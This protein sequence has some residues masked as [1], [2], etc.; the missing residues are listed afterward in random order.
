MSVLWNLTCVLLCPLPG[1]WPSKVVRAGERASLPKQRKMPVLLP[2]RLGLR[3]VFVF[4]QWG[5]ALTLPPSRTSLV[6]VEVIVLENEWA[7]QPL[8]LLLSSVKALLWTEA[9]PVCVYW[10]EGWWEESGTLCFRV[11]NSDYL[12]ILDYCEDL[13]KTTHLDCF[14]IYSLK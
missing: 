10:S 4:F 13:L 3:E 2:S 7:F 1:Q 9:L 6:F 8:G 5:M 11:V 12:R 14:C